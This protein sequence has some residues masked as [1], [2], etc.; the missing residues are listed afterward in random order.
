MNPEFKLL[1]LFCLAGV[2]ALGLPWLAWRR[3]LSLE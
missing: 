3:V 1:M 2:F